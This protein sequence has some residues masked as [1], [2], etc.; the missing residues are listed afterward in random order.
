[1]R[2]IWPVDARSTEVIAWNIVPADESGADLDARVN[3]LPLFQGPG[4]FATPDDVEA[5]ESCQAGFA[6]REVEWTDL[7]RGI[8]RAPQSTDEAQIRAF[9]RQWHADL[10]S[11]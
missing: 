10:L 3:D 2:T 9:W 11:E 4:G 7:S 5:L 6:A 8:E 1:V